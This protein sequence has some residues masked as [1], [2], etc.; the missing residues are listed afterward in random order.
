MELRKIAVLSV[1]VG[2]LFA[3]NGLAKG[4]GYGKGG[5]K[6]QPVS[7]NMPTFQERDSNGDGVITQAEFD[8][9]K[10]A[11]MLKNAEAGKQLRNAGNSPQFADIDVNSDGK[12]TKDELLSAQQSHKTNQGKMKAQ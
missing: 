10:E 4:D 9:F 1:I 12:I 7:Q 5:N 2:I 11:R 3:T 6:Q 8:S